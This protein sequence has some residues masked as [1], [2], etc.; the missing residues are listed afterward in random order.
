MRLQVN[1]RLWFVWC[2]SCL[3]SFVPSARQIAAQICRQAGLVRKSKD[4]M[5]YTE[6]NFAI[7][8][9]AMGVR[10]STFWHFEGCVL[11]QT[12]LWHAFRRESH[13]VRLLLRCSSVSPRLST[14]HVFKC[15][16]IKK[17]RECK[18]RTFEMMELHE[19]WAL[20]EQEKRS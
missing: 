9:A 6:D 19:E 11:A 14:R 8:F 15:L 16:D 13:T 7:V 18:S 5:D 2:P 20:G 4:V 1:K 10:I 17:G 12:R 3:S